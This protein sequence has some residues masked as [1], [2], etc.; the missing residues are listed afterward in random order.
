MQKKTAVYIFLIFE[1]IAVALWA[2]YENKFYLFNFSF[3]GCSLGFGCYLKALKHKFARMYVQ[4]LIGVY[5]LVY[6]GLVLKENIMLEGFWY[7]TF[8]GVLQAATL[9]YFVA[10]IFGPFLFGRG[11]CGYGCWTAVIFDLLPYKQ[12]Q[13]ERRNNINWIKYILFVL[14][15]LFVGSLFFFDI[16]N[17]ED[18]MFISF[19]AFNF[20]YY[21]TGIIMAFA[22]RDNR[23]FC[24]YIC[25]IV[26]FLK[27]ASYFSLIKVR[28]EPE[29]CVKCN[30]CRHVC[31]MNVDM[32][33][34][35]RTRTRTNGTECILCSSCV[36]I[37]PANALKIC[38][39]SRK[40]SIFNNQTERHYSDFI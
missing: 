37:C 18:V 14:S 20:I 40:Y 34:N 5:L 24:K 12:P 39:P 15:F 17:I 8:L 2:I 21:M 13:T 31:P 33:S 4:L 28:H 3:L 16:Q 38:L 7:Y 30:K 35:S 36:E 9:H 26:V 22:L 29:K 19:I 1:I 27:P 10:K 25:P 6:V 32:M 11:W 23:A